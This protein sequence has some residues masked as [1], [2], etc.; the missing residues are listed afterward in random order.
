MLIVYPRAAAVALVSLLVFAAVLLLGPDR[1][2][3]TVPVGLAVAAAGV[4]LS[5]LVARWE[6]RRRGGTGE[7]GSGPIE[8]L[9]PGSAG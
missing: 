1:P 9:G 6:A 4:L 2:G 3:V 5:I 8:P 7:E